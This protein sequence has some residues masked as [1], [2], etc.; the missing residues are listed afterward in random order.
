VR[1]ATLL[2][3]FQVKFLR[4]SRDASLVRNELL[5]QPAAREICFAMTPRGC[6]QFIITNLLYHKI[7]PAGEKS[8]PAC[9]VVFKSGKFVVSKSGMNFTSD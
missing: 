8:F 2:C 9:R 3:V 7:R 5:S 1:A 4:L 6:P